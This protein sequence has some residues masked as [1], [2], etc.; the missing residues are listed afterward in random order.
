M[1]VSVALPV[2]VFLLFARFVCVCVLEWF[3]WFGKCL[4]SPRHFPRLIFGDDKSGDLFTYAVY[5]AFIV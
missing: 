5:L 1:Y 2:C 4:M 3:W